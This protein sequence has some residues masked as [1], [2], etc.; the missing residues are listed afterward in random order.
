VVGLGNP[1][2][3]D[4]GV[5]WK[6]AEEVE[7]LLG[8]AAGGGRSSIQVDYSSLGGLSLMESLIG[9][10][11]AILVDA[12]ALDEPTGTV[13]SFAL[14]DLPNYATGHTGSAHD[15]SLQDALKMGKAMGASLPSKITVV[16]IAAMRLYDFSEALSPEAAASIEPAA[17][18]VMD[19]LRQEP[20][21]SRPFIDESHP[22]S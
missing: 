9:Y 17:K 13:L 22:Q 20:V 7:R 11:E 15:T 6:V 3:G 2:L 10:D 21:G 8:P 18:A 16:G 19:L 12:L 1:I 14:E 5:G 4:D